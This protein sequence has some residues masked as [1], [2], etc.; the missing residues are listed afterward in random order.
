MGV[1][2]HRVSNGFG[3]GQF[4]SSLT[5]LR[6]DLQNL[7]G[8]KADLGGPQGLGS[9]LL[10]LPSAAPRMQ[11]HLCRAGGQE[12]KWA[13]KCQVSRRKPISSLVCQ[14]KSYR[15]TLPINTIEGKGTNRGIFATA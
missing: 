1:L 12:E 8:M 6:F 11:G 5:L 15:I 9:A 7:R 2:K 10:S 13:L 3:G 14:C 4:N